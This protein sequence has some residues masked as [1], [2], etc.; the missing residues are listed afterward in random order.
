MKHPLNTANKSECV[1]DARRYAS[2]VAA[3]H[4]MLWPC[5]TW[6]RYCTKQL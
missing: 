3:V 5:V 1:F 4:V 6:R 2:A